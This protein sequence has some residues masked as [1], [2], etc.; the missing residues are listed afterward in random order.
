M[1]QPEPKIVLFDGVCNFCS[2]TVSFISKRDPK[3]T[4]RFAALQTNLGQD[5]LKKHGLP[6]GSLDTFVLIDGDQ[7]RLRSDA[8]L[9]V[10]RDLSAPW[11][12]LGAF[13]VVP[14]GLRNA[15]YNLVAR[16]RYRWFGKKE[17]CM[18]PTPELRE[19]FLSGTE[20]VDSDV[21]EEDVAD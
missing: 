7:A 11:P 1:D 9:A 3:G 10:A 19:R 8:A 4:F 14:K 12:L 5:L 2:G 16:N 18:V 21:K 6:T 20:P 15:V 13:R 17:T